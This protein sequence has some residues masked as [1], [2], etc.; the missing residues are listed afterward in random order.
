LLP[1]AELDVAAGAGVAGGGR[2]AQQVVAGLERVERQLVAVLGGALVERRAGSRVAPTCR[3]L[4]RV[5]RIN[6]VFDLQKSQRDAAAR[7][8]RTSRRRGRAGA[9]EAR[10]SA[11]VLLHLRSL[12]LGHERPS[13]AQVRRDLDAWCA[14]R[15]LRTASRATVYNV[16]PAIKGHAYRV[17]DLPAAV[18]HALYNLGPDATV[19]GHQLAFYCL[20]YGSPAAVSYAAGLPWL[21]LFQAARLRGWRPGSRGLLTAILRARA[22]RRP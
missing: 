4:F 21:D 2:E 15:Q 9:G 16:L 19:P 8:R 5:S 12:L 14:R 7:L 3:G 11:P 20:N 10:L 22:R 6:S 17:R 1:D 18:R 13:M